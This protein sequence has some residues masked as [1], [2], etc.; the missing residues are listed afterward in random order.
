[1]EDIKDFME[2]SKFYR[3]YGIPYHRGYLLYGPPGTG[4]TSVISAIAGYLNVDIC[5]INL[6]EKGLTD[7][8]LCTL[9]AT[10]PSP[11]IL[12]LEDIDAAFGSREQ[13]KAST[14]TTKL[15]ATS[16]QAFQG[17]NNLTFSGLLNAL[18]GVAAAEN[19]MVFMTTNH[20]ELLDPALIRPGRVDFKQYIGYASDSQIRR[21]FL[22]FFKEADDKEVHW[23]VQGVRKMHEKSV[24]VAHLQNLLVRHRKKKEDMFSDAISTNKSDTNS[25]T[26][27]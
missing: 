8:T 9:L 14:E 15:E 10:A 19:K 27:D 21:M 5:V 18:D 24:S 12:L 1:M 3:E 13:I 22:R 17:M 23:F 20:I 11:S 2:S 16:M 6:S 25:R 26:A 7:A 4:K